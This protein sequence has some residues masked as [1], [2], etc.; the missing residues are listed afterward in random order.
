[1]K[2]ADFLAEENNNRFLAWTTTWTLP[3]NTAL[4]V[5]NKID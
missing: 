3:S 4:T 1:M 2:P 5:G